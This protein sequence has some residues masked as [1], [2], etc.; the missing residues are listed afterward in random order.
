MVDAST[1]SGFS[2]YEPAVAGASVSTLCTPVR[3]TTSGTYVAATS[4]STGVDATAGFG[5]S[6]HKLVPA[7]SG[8]A[9]SSSRNAI[10]TGGSRAA[11]CAPG[12]VTTRGS[13][14]ADISCSTRVDAT[15]GSG[16]GKHKLVPAAAGAAGAADS[17]SRNAIATGCSLAAL[18]A[19]VRITTSGTYVA[20]TSCSTGVDATA[21][22][23]LSKQFKHFSATPTRCNAW[24]AISELLQPAIT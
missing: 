5:L 6:K 4:C 13:Y 14:V 12:R 16:L 24:A 2:Q 22:F 21:G 8:A 23:V 18:C 3:V 9:D 15:A 10:A 7:A 1:S 20:A 11:L 17:S 19:P